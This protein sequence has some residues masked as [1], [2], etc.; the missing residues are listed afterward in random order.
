[1]QVATLSEKAQCQASA[2]S[3]TAALNCAWRD[4]AQVA[5]P[6]LI[7]LFAKFDACN[8]VFALLIEQP[9]L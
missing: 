8:F 1:M 6:N 5:V 2:Q 9:D 3:G 7:G 4:S